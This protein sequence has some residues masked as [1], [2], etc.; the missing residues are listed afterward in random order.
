[1]AVTVAVEELGCVAGA[2]VVAVVAA[3]MVVAGRPGVGFGFES[4]EPGD[5]STVEGGPPGFLGRAVPMEAL[6]DRVEVR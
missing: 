6:D 5:P 3:A 1:L 2:H 4:V